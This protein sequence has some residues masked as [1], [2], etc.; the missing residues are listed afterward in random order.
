M[1]IKIKPRRKK[2]KL[3]NNWPV[4]RRWVAMGSLVA[5]STVGTRT[6]NLARAQDLGANAPA[7]RPAYQTQGSLPARRFDIAAG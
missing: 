6:D 2:N 3:K 5:Y 7:N 4:A 1:R